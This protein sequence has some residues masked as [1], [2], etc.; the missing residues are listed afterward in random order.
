VVVVVRGA[1]RTITTMMMRAGVLVALH[2]VFAADLP[3]CDEGV[4]HAVD[5]G[6]KM[7]RFLTTTGTF[8][9]PSVAGPVPEAQCL[10]FNNVAGTRCC[11]DDDDY[12]VD[13]SLCP[14]GECV[15]ENGA[16]SLCPDGDCDL[17]T[18]VQAK[19]RCESLGMR[20]CT[21]TEILDDHKG[22]GTGCGFDEA[23]V[24]TVTAEASVTSFEAVGANFSETILTSGTVL[25]KS[26]NGIYFDPLPASFD[27]EATA[28]AAKVAFKVVD[29]D[30]GIASFGVDSEAPFRLSDA[31][32]QETL[33]M[34]S[35]DYEVTV[36]PFAD[37]GLEGARGVYE[38][39]VVDE[40]FNPVDEPIRQTDDR[41][42]NVL[43]L[44]K[45]V[46]FPTDADSDPRGSSLFT[47]RRLRINCLVSRGDFLYVCME[48]IGI[49]RK[50]NVTSGEFDTWADIYQLIEDLTNRSMSN[51]A[52]FPHSGLRGIA[53]ADDFETSGLFYT[54]H[55]ETPG[56]SDM[57][58]L[59]EIFDDA[60]GDSVVAEWRFDGDA[61]GE[62]RQL[63]RISMPT[64]DDDAYTNPI[65]QI[66]MRDGHLYVS[67]GDGY[68]EDVDNDGGRGNDAFGKILRVTPEGVGDFDYSIPQ[69]NPFRDDESYPDEAF[70]VGFRN[71]HHLFFTDD[72]DL[73]CADTGRDNAEEINVILSGKDYG[74]NER[75]GPFVHD[76]SGGGLIH[77]VGLDLP[78]D[79]ADYG[80][81]Y[82]AAVF[83]H[84]GGKKGAAYQEVVSQSIAGGCPL[85][86][87]LNSDL[88]GRVFYGDFP[89][90]GPIFYS[91]LDDILN[92]VTEG[93]PAD[94]EQA[95]TY[96][97]TLDYYD[98]DGTTLIMSTIHFRDI[99]AYEAEIKGLSEPTRNDMRFG[100]G[101][102][103]ELLVSSK[104]DGN[105]YTVL[106]SH[107]NSQ[108]ASR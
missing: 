104:R 99:V 98:T 2:Q 86:S 14:D 44:K 10:D 60:V 22:Q 35:S 92:A 4:P 100:N 26:T 31:L 42:T 52:T 67:M 106:N 30:T 33:V 45:I 93:D 53:F 61:V 5:G 107:P 48:S 36:T 41:G 90:R 21:T 97:A 24:W 50:V 16:T 43:R 13:S 15:Y 74:W 28:S 81:T 54:S 88:D 95:P 78:D 12:V 40:P 32:D 19:A 105:I 77:G 27:L 68:T 7:N 83:G 3:V 20:L 73:I 91:Y 96:L 37:D 89:E 17:V 18:F 80:Y 76:T 39:S 87:T 23:P 75:E 56:T 6:P 94:L 58:Y 64:F 46:S 51:T 9:C 84:E 108:A 101:P 49:I 66:T 102:N 82:P 25:Y 71:P 70:A 59:G 11:D 29:K 63:F 57:T 65:K 85:S 103:G 1:S 72:G 34:P 55:L 47:S 38:F 79:D 69:S 62:Y 8:V